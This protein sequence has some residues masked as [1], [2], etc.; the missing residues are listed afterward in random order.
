MRIWIFFV[1]LI[2]ISWSC[3]THSSTSVKE[4]N[5]EDSVIVQ[6]IKPGVLNILNSQTDPGCHYGLYLPKDSA[7][8]YPL[9][10]LFD[11]HAAGNHAAS[12]YQELAEK[13]NIVLVASN[14][15]Q[16]GMASDKYVY[17]AN[18]MIADV[19]NLV[20][21]DSEYVYLMGFS[22]GARVAAFLAQSENVFR[23]IIG[24]GAGTPEVANIQTSN[25]LYIG[26]AGY[27]DFNFSEVYKSESFIRESQLRASFKYFEGSHEWPPD[28][29]MEFAFAAVSLDKNKKTNSYIRTFLDEECN[30]CKNIP[31]RDSW[32][33]MTNYRSIRDLIESHT[34][35]DNIRAK[36]NDYLSGYESKTAEKNLT[37][38]FLAESKSQTDMQN[39]LLE[40]D[41]DWWKKEIA[42]LN[43]A[44]SKKDKSPS[45]YKDIRILN[46][47]SMSCFM[48]VNS[49][50]NNNDFEKTKK[51]LSIYNIVDPTNSD[52]A[53]S[54]GVLYAK[55]NNYHDAIDS[56]S[57]A[58]K[59]GYSDR[60][61][62]KSEQAF[63]PLKDSLRFLDLESKLNAL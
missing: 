42:L 60:L 50:L 24:C 10:V 21:I 33:K 47:L 15:I 4:N 8:Q 9:I 20:P 19:M 18:C 52:L 25:F 58:I 6:E 29:I 26:F 14:N 51:F 5:L 30:F 3:N 49:A 56:L 55:T 22:G 35:L 44:V 1:G 43:Q 7:K 12:K 54:Y 45:D 48:M 61:R 53:Y 13:Y 32:K 46:Y 17:Y 62:W 57:S 59:K 27:S 40:K 11:P 38:S 23:G 63:I 36:V 37:K 2:I 16:N 34:G 28:T 39:A 31:I 41:I